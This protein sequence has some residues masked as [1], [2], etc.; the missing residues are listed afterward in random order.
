MK[1]RE[2]TTLLGGAALVWPI[3]ARAQQKGMPVIGFLGSTPSGPYAPFV[4]AFLQG[5]SE[6]GYIDGRNVA[7]EYRWAEGHY[8]RLP[9]LAADLVRQRVAVILA[10]GSTAP[11]LAAKAATAEIDEI[12]CF[13]IRPLPSSPFRLHCHTAAGVSVLTTWITL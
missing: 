8:D 3:T 1:R 10:T 6:G 9:A 11:A 5:L 4:A 7:I 13:I 2:F 12:G